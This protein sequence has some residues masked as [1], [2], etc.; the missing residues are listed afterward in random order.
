MDLLL[1]FGE[2]VIYLGP[3]LGLKTIHTDRVKFSLQ[4][5]T[6]RDYTSTMVAVEVLQVMLCPDELFSQVALSGQAPRE[7]ILKI[8]RV[9]FWLP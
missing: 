9:N 2:N 5:D 4:L 7:P 6:L 1:S 8:G 3:G